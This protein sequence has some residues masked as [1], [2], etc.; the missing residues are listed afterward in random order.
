MQHG[1]ST[2][3]NTEHCGLLCPF[4]WVFIFLHMVGEP[5]TRSVYLPFP[6]IVSYHLPSSPF[7]YHRLPLSL[8]ISLH[9]LPSSPIIS[10]RVS[11]SPDIMSHHHLP[12]P[13]ICNIVDHLHHIIISYHFPSYP[14]VFRQL[15]PCLILYQIPP[16][17]MSDHLPSFPPS[18]I[19]SHYLL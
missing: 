2:A 13:T 10:H 6:P 5:T 9:L 4:A 11:S 14:T 17:T 1:W 15:P 16:P 8:A 7:V 3:R 18:P 12:L 19:I